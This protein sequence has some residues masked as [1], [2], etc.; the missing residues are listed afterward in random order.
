MIRVE[1]IKMLRRPRTWLIIGMLVFDK[2][3]V[4]DDLVDAADTVEAVER[5]PRGRVGPVDDERGDRTGK[6]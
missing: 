1:L 2:Q 5:D 3:T 4:P 6:E